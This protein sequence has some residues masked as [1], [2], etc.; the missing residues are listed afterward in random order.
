MMDLLAIGDLM[1][2]FT[3]AGISPKGNPVYEQNPGGAPANVCVTLSRLGGKALFL[4][5]VGNEMFGRFLQKKLEEYNVDGRGLHFSSEGVT[6]LSFVTL[7]ANHDRSFFFMPSP[8]AEIHL[9]PEDI[10][11]T[12]LDECK[13][14]LLSTVS[15]YQEPIRSTSA[16]LIEQAHNRGR[17]VAYDPNWNKAFSFDPSFEREVIRSTIAKAD[18]VKIS[19]EEANFVYGDTS[20]EALA[21]MAMEE[22]VKLFTMTSGAKGCQ[23]CYAGGSGKVPGFRI[24]AIDTTGAGDAFMGGLIYSLTRP[25][26]GRID[27]ISPQKMHAI[28]SF[29]NACGA[30]CATKR[31]GMPSVDGIEE[32]WNC[33]EQFKPEKKQ[34]K[35][36]D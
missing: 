13:V 23:Y 19:L 11:T 1:I 27:S 25:D 16:W 10:D 36:E 14:F 9:R 24:E 29:A 26:I 22:G 35:W 30:V 33:M 28:L 17:L 5:S 12:L 21:S 8:L 31:G 2:D 20:F 6:K 15:Q 18:I 32:V 3:P 34:D 7:D 4:G